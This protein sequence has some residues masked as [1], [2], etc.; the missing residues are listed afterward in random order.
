[1]PFHLPTH[2]E[3]AEFHA[4]ISENV[5]RNLC[6]RF[7]IFGENQRMPGHIY[8]PVNRDI[9]LDMVNHFNKKTITLPSNDAR[10]GKLAVDCYHAPGLAKA[11][12]IL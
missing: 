11:C 8:V 2:F 1:M 9:V 10:P 7:S 3:A 5:H 4:C 12:H 6:K